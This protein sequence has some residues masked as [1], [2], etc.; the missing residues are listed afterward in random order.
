MLMPLSGQLS[1]V[2]PAKAG[3]HQTSL[4]LIL[5]PKYDLY[6][7]S[8]RFSRLLRSSLLSPRSGKEYS[9]G[10]LLKSACYSL[11]CILYFSFGICLEFGIL[12][13]KR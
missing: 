9:E 2:V 4:A 8:P 11:V 6:P 10:E 12:L 13:Q 3:I 1:I 7:H 5:T